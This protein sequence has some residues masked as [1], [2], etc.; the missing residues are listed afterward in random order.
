MP[1]IKRIALD[2]MLA[3]LYFALSF[4]TVPI[5]GNLQVRF[6]SLVLI[7]AALLFGTLDAC[8][9]ALIGEGLYQV[10]LFGVTA[11]TPVWLLPPIL[12][13]LALGLLAGIGRRRS[14]LE[15]RPV[16]CYAV[17]LGCG[18]FNS[19]LNTLALY[20][21][22]RVFGYYSFELVFGVALLR[23]AI[24]LVTAGLVTTAAIPLVRIL[25]KKRLMA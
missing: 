6:T 7:V 10:I 19:V 14:P 11:T 24:G 9:V 25:K 3:A 22:S 17:C 16:A 5:G 1:K 21:D 13:A 15:Q 23:F 2:G 20:V 8:A 12:H 18:L 4:L